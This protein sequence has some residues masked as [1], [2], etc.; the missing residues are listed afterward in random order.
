MLPDDFSNFQ[1]GLVS[2]ILLNDF[3]FVSVVHSSFMTHLAYKV[4]H[5]FVQQFV[6]MVTI[7]FNYW[8]LFYNYFVE[9]IYIFIF[10]N[11][12]SW[13]VVK[14]YYNFFNLHIVLEHSVLIICG[15]PYLLMLGL[16]GVLVA[17]WTSVLVCAVTSGGLTG[18]FSR[19]GGRGGVILA[20]LMF[21]EG[22]VRTLVQLLLYSYF[23]P[24]TADR[25]YY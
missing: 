16:F 5:W 13:K 17:V 25:H 24:G 3:R 19:W 21:K 14:S 20:A 4:V 15:K 6:K 1:Y 11:D 10:L 18:V 9:I 7:F 8:L 2:E 12:I 22:H 23:T